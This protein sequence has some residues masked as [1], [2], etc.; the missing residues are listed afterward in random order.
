MQNFESARLVVI[1]DLR[2]QTATVRFASG[3]KTDFAVK[4]LHPLVCLRDQTVDNE[5]PRGS[6]PESHLGCSEA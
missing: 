5:A 2:N 1:E 3:R 4:D 6:L